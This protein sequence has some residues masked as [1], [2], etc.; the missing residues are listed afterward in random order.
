MAQ[1]IPAVLSVVG[2]GVG[3]AGSIIG[4]RDK[5]RELRSEADQLET[6]AGLTRATSQRQSI[7]ERRQAKLVESRA[8]ALAAANGGGSD[9]SVVK[10]ISE[11]QGEGE[12]R[13]L[14]ALYEGNERAAGMEGEAAAKRRGAKSVKTAAAFEAAGSIIKAG[15]SLAQRYG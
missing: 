7:E 15:S 1:A 11:I 9:V 6:Q 8:Q 12:Y 5:A 4:A 13:A 14:T 3:A 10:A 2:A